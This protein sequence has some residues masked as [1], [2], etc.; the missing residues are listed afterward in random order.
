MKK[1]LIVLCIAFVISAC[2]QSPI[3]HE[4]ARKLSNCPQLEIASTAILI[5]RHNLGMMEAERVV[6]NLS[7]NLNYA[8]DI[9]YGIYRVV[10]DDWNFSNSNNDGTLNNPFDL[11]YMFL[12]D[13]FTVREIRQIWNYFEKRHGRAVVRNNRNFNQKQLSDFFLLAIS[14]IE[15][16]DFRDATRTLQNNGF[17]HFATAN[18]LRMFGHNPNTTAILETGNNQ[19]NSIMVI[20]E[21]VSETNSQISSATF[22]SPEIMNRAIR[23][24]LA[25]AGFRAISGRKYKN[26]FNDIL[27]DS[28]Y[29]KVEEAHTT[30]IVV[31]I[32]PQ[33]GIIGQAVFLRDRH[34]IADQNLPLHVWN[35]REVMARIQEEKEMQEHGDRLHREALERLISSSQMFYDATSSWN[36]GSEPL[37]T[38]F[39]RFNSDESFRKSRMRCAHSNQLGDIQLKIQEIDWWFCHFWELE[40][41]FASFICSLLESCGRLVYIFERIGGRWYLTQ[42]PSCF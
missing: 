22:I 33:T 14:T 17:R 11:F 39:E 8:E 5:E 7:R 40:A 21:A 4:I 20:L 12:A 19:S 3:T 42:C 15:A 31:T 41:N 1:I 9:L 23:K 37:K 16:S 30:T 32:D 27:I 18:E 28:T 2:N 38:F 26:E 36:Q 10:V 24:D 25:N 34:V 13:C 35:E 29:Q 6:R